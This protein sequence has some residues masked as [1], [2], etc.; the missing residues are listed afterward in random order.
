MADLKAAAGACAISLMSESEHGQA[1][2]VQQDHTSSRWDRRDT[3]N[4]TRS[5]PGQLAEGQLVVPAVLH[6]LGKHGK[7]IDSATII[8]LNL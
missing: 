8:P 4:G 7:S 1:V 2:R 3:A 6:Q 5:P